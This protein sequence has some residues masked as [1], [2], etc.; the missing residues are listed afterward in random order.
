MG[1]VFVIRKNLANASYA[2][3]L[4]LRN[5]KCFRRLTEAVYGRAGFRYG[6]KKQ[7]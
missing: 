5:G 2:K 4:E 7:N 3:A 1:V 6:W